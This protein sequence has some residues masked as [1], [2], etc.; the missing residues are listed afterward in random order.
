M[1]QK[2]FGDRL[3]LALSHANISAAALARHLGITRGA[4]YQLLDGQSAAMSAQNCLAAAE[5]LGVNAAW[6][7]TGDGAMAL[8]ETPLVSEVAILRHAEPMPASAADL[9]ELA[10]SLALAFSA[11][12]DAFAVEIGDDANTPR[13]LIGE[14]ALIEP[15]E[16]VEIED[17]VLAVRHDGTWL[18]RR[19]V[20]QRGATVLSA[21]NPSRGSV[22]ISSDELRALYPVAHRIPWRRRRSKV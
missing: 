5:H 14:L 20:S 4:V 21:W 16:P 3:R 17:D 1:P 18:V 8:I 10:T 9:R 12:G 7:A 13:Y 11:D 22:S 6:L 15:S 19:L 2:T